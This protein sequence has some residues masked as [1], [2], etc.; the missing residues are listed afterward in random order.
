[1]ESLFKALELLSTS[2]NDFNKSFVAN[3]YTFILTTRNEVNC[4]IFEPEHSEADGMIKD[5]IT[6]RSELNFKQNHLHLY[7]D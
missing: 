3:G 5:R 2:E 4:S 1:M 7:N 6:E